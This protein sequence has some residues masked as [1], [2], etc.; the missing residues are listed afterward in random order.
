M[1]NPGGMSAGNIPG[2]MGSM[3]GNPIM[4]G[5]QMHPGQMGGINENYSMSQ[6]QTINFTQQSMRQRTNGVSGNSRYFKFE[7]RNLCNQTTD[8]NKYFHSGQ[9]FHISCKKMYSFIAIANFH[10]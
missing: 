1:Q 3:S 2:G 4:G 8:K 6:N 7:Y 5:A 9:M 10:I